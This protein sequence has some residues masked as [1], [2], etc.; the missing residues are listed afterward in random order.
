MPYRVFCMLGVP[1]GPSRAHVSTPQINEKHGFLKERKKGSEEREGGGKE[2]GGGKE[3]RYHISA[4]WGLL[5]LDKYSVG[6][7]PAWL[8]HDLPFF[9]IFFLVL[10]LELVLHSLFIVLE[11][12]W[13][14]KR[15]GGGIVDGGIV[16]GTVAIFIYFCNTENVVLVTS[17]RY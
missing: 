8:V 12:L 17:N 6:S 5:S 10:G 11:L 3:E 16:K 7:D 14:W 15:L 9:T 1:Q 13:F 4:I 2:R